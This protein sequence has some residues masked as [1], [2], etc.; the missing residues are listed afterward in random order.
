MR[1]INSQAF[2]IEIKA[3]SADLKLRDNTHGNLAICPY[4]SGSACWT[5]YVVASFQTSPNYERAAAYN[6]ETNFF[7]A[8]AGRPDGT[9]AF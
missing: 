9:A 1:I 2:E 7:D 8:K 5:G 4:S 6:A 3:I